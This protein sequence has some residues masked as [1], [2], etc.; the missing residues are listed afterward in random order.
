M[1]SH[2]RVPGILVAASVIACAATLIGAEVPAGASGTSIWNVTTT[3]NPKPAQVNDTYFAG[4][5]ASGPDEAWAVGTY[6][7][8]EALDAPLAEHW[9]GTTWTQVSVPQPTGQQ[10]T[11]DAVDDLGPDDAWAVGTSFSGGAGASPAGV[12]LIENWNG[13]SWS[14]VPSPNGASGTPGDANIL[15]AIAATGPDN[16]WAAGWV[17]NNDADTLTMLFEQWNGTSWSVVP[18][19][20]NGSKFEIATSLTAISPND[21]W[22]VGSYAEDG[23]L[24]ANWNGKKWSIVPTPEITNTG[25]E[26]ENT[27]TAVT[28]DGP[29]DV[30][31]SGYADV[32]SENFATP[33][34]LHWQGSSW[35]LTEVPNLGTEGSRLRSIQLVS[36]SDVWAVGQEQK[37]NGSILS[38]TEQFNGSKWTVVPSPDPGMQGKLII[39]S[40]DGI[41]SAGGGNLIAV[42]ARETPGQCCLRT[43]AIGTTEG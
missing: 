14:I 3:V 13:T 27:L 43:L 2:L 18:S 42:G 35:T 9:N 34:V 22:A 33:Y 36:R 8:K 39:N 12:T 1:K 30:W 26:T 38:L 24:A 25:P 7:D 19:P 40:L 23:T 6:A 31:A 21:V 37:N 29:D 32:D 17:D 41:G 11:F 5:S 16:V 4:V 10:A 15:D 28:A 20:G